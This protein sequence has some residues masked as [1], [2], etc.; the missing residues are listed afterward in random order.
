M[1]RRFAYTLFLLSLLLASGCSSMEIVIPGSTKA[2]FRDEFVP[3]HTGNWSLE[4]D[5]TGSTAIV[6]EQLLIELHAPHLVQYAMLK[7]PAFADFTL[8]V[9]GRLLSG[10]PVSSYGVLF[11][12][13]GP[14]Q[15][16]RFALT[17]D[18]M[19]ILE[20][21]DGDGSRVMLT[22]DWRDATAVKQGLGTTNHFKITAKGSEIALFA[23]GTLL[24]VFNDASYAQGTIALDAGTFSD[25]DLQVAFDNLIILPPQAN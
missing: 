12:Q 20:R 21:H 25:G 7:E 2:L 14:Q 9:D 18:G 10:S 13:Q 3:G 4:S 19:Y 15:F 11:R 1:A 24:D 23:N 22:G 5:E 6:P 16:Y 8:E 17:G